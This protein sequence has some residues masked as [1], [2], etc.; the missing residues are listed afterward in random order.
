MTT[1]TINPPWIEYPNSDPWWGGWR[2]GKSEAWFLNEWLPFWK[3]LSQQ[4]KESYVKQW[5]LPN[6]DWQI[7]LFEY[8]K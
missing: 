7:Y 3:S 8:W 2:Q 5:P 6:D 4:E 1:S